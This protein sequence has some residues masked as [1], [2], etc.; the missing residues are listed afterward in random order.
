MK[1]LLRKRNFTFETLS[2]TQKA[3]LQ[4]PRNA[5]RL[6]QQRGQFQCTREETSLSRL[7]IMRLD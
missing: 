5:Q 2:A 1:L 7:F 6:M 3:D 4:M